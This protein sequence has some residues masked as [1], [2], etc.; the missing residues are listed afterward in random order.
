MSLEAE[1]KRE[2]EKWTK[3]IE[4]EIVNV[5]LKDASKKRLLENVN[6]YVKDS[7]YF[8]AKGDLIRSFEA[9]VWA[10]SWLEILKEME[11]LE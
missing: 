9:I 8:L 5:K 6:A 1:L 4:K 10:W 3:K 11:I 2:T 7:K